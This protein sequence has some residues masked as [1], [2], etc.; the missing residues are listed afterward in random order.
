MVN[1]KIFF[2]IFF[3][4]KENPSRELM[5]MAENLWRNYMNKYGLG[6]DAGVVAEPT[7][8]EVR[9]ITIL[10]NAAIEMVEKQMAEAEAEEAKRKKLQKEA[11]DLGIYPPADI[12]VAELEAMVLKAMNPQPEEVEEAPVEEPVAEAAEEVVEEAAEEVQEPVV[13]EAPAKAVLEAP[14]KEI[15]VKAVEKKVVKSV[16]VM[17]A[18]LVQTDALSLWITELTA[19]C[20]NKGMQCITTADEGDVYLHVYFPHKKDVFTVGKWCFQA[21]M[22]GAALAAEMTKLFAY[23]EGFADC[24]EKFMK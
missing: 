19:W 22:G 14:V 15:P 6:L 4:N 17:A 16:P 7:Y 10:A 18:P 11:W 23:C 5:E 20:Q 1:R 8:D 9:E 13:E 3:Y 21:D 2:D 12:A 24:I